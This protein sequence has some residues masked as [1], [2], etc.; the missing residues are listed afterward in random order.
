MKE[1]ETKKFLDAFKFHKEYWKD[2]HYDRFVDQLIEEMSELTKILLKE[3]RGRNVQEEI[4]GETGDVLLCL[5]YLFVN[6]G[7]NLEDFKEQVDFKSDRMVA[8]LKKGKH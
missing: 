3:R 8:A 4:K 5:K 2:K 6:K 7:Y 1:L